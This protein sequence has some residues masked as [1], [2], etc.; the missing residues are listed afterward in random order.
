LEKLRSETRTVLY[1]VVQEA[2]V[3]TGKHSRASEV[4]VRFYEE[5]KAVRL[6]INDNGCGFAIEGAGTVRVSKRLGLLGM[7]ERVEMVGGSF[8]VESAPGKGTA[9]RIRIPQRT[10]QSKQGKSKEPTRENL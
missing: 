6:E 4:R 5:G 3:N 8:S 2:L 9:V 10:R 7:R 1:R